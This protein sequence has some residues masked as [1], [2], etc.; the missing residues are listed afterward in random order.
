MVYVMLRCM[1]ACCGCTVRHDAMQWS[2]VERSGSS[3]KGDA[4][5]QHSRPPGRRSGDEA[6]SATEYYR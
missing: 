3:M 6:P 2:G 5:V 4:C 1:G